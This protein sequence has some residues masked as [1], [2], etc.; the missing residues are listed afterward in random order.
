MPAKRK[1]NLTI[2]S[3]ENSPGDIFDIGRKKS[4]RIIN[5]TPSGTVDTP[6]GTVGTPSGTVDTPIGTPND[7]LCGLRVCVTGVTTCISRDRLEEILREKGVSVTSAVSGLTNILICGSL[8]EDGRGVAEGS[9]YKKAKSLLDTGKTKGELR[10]MNEAEF[11]SEYKIV[12]DQVT[13]AIQRNL[14]SDLNGVIERANDNFIWT[15]RWRPMKETDF[16]TARAA[17][18]SLKHWLSNWFEKYE[19]DP[20]WLR[21]CLLVGPPGVGKTSACHV[22]VES[23]GYKLR[24]FNASDVRSQKQLKGLNDLIM[25]GLYLSGD[26]T[27]NNKI[28]ILMD[29]ADGLGAGDRGGSQE[30]MRLIKAT[31]VPILCTCNDSQNTKVRSLSKLCK[32]IQFYP[33]DKKLAIDRVSQIVT[34][35]GFNPKHIS[36]LLID[37]FDRS[38]GDLRQYITSVQMALIGPPG[39]DFAKSISSTISNKDQSS[40]IDP[41][42]SVRELYRSV[43]KMS[44]REKL[45]VFFLDYSMVPLII[46]ENSLKVL[47]LNRDKKAALFKSR[48]IC[49]T[50]AY[51][52][53][54]SNR[55][56]LQGQWELL[57]DQGFFS[58]VLPAII[59]GGGQTPYRMDFPRLLGRISSQSK[60]KRQ[61]AELNIHL[62]RNGGTYRNLNDGAYELLGEIL[63]HQA[64]IGA[65]SNY[66][67]N[68]LSNDLKSIG[69]NKDLLVENLMDIRINKFVENPYESCL[70]SKAKS[71]ITRWFKNE[72]APGSIT[73]TAKKGKKVATTD[74]IPAPVNRLTVSN[75]NTDE[76]I[77][78][79]EVRM[80]SIY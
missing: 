61:I 32:I 47:L 39:K 16:N 79:E 13:S 54:I 73:Q 69:L 70:D 20:K 33:I 23:M 19:T 72:I 34:A 58:T 67:F 42:I 10:I 35:E 45:D 40:S 65:K 48:D 9:K 49:D 46:Y 57:P 30:L 59:I 28:V 6:S 55:I 8:L 17:Y 80:G 38:G 2:V 75:D 15:E 7:G 24:E 18:D 11:L 44:S 63:I 5:D 36:Q 62:G 27:A 53:R 41:F 29:E 37:L 26:M 66:Q 64:V 12:T 52:E 71:S 31:K 51:S 77:H 56:R 60:H 50:I 21:G 25:G 43:N 76:E 68:E 74:A 22:V 3:D 14:S 4:S 78:E 1:R